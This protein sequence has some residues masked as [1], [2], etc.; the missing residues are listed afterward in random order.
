M[1]FLYWK[2]RHFHTCDQADTIVEKAL[3]TLMALVMER[4]SNVVSIECIC[5]FEKIRFIFHYCVND[6]KKNLN[7]CIGSDQWGKMIWIFP[8]V[9]ICSGP[10]AITQMAPNDFFPHFSR[11]FLL[12]SAQYHNAIDRSVIDNEKKKNGERRHGTDNN[13]ERIEH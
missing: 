5:K 11:S 8:V 1:L 6:Q 4:C 3:L 7:I 10:F 9:S 12:P 2:L 13:S